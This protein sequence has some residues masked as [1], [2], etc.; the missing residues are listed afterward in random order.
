[1]KNKAF[2][3]GFRYFNNILPYVL[4]CF[5]LLTI[6]LISVGTWFE[7]SSTYD[8][9]VWSVFSIDILMINL[10]VLCKGGVNI[11]EHG[12]T[13]RSVAYIVLFILIFVFLDIYFLL[14]GFNLLFNL[15]SSSL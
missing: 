4:F 10:L 9:L 7:N 8:F 13:F 14:L 12:L 6:V 1:M 2:Y 11:K 5:A 15:N 3:A